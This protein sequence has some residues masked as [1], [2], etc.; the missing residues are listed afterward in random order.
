[1]DTKTYL[2]RT[3]IANTRAAFKQPNTLS[4]MYTT[5]I[6]FDNGGSM[7]DENAPSAVS[8][9]IEPPKSILSKIKGFFER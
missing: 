6:N 5:K 8:N 1:M 4:D 2:E 7:D 3:K 9:S